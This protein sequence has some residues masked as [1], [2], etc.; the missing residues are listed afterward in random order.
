MADEILGTTTAG[1]A[2]TGG[3]EGGAAPAA[4]TAPS[5]APSPAPSGSSLGGETSPQAAGAQ[6]GQAQ[7]YLGVRDALA[8]YGVDLRTQFNDDHAALQHLALAYRQASQGNELAQYG[9]QYLQ[10]AGDFQAYLAQRQQQAVQQKQG[11]QEWFKA[12]EYDQRWQHQI[13]RD[14]ATGEMRPAPGAPPDV[15]QKY[16]AW[17]NHQQDFQTR[18]ARDP[19][20]TLKPGLEQLVQET[21]QRLIEQQLGG[22]QERT[23]AQGF[24]Q[25]HSG[26]LH[27]RDQQGNVVLDPRTGRP[28]LSDLGQ[29]FAGYVHE[30][31]QFG[32]RDVASQQKYAMGLVQRDYLAAQ[33]GGAQAQAQ[34]QANPAQLAADA[35]QATRDAFLANA[36]AH[37]PNVSG[38]VSPTAPNG[39]QP[40]QNT[41]LSLK[42]RL[43]Q[44]FTENG[45]QLSTPVMG[46]R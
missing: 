15:V 16:V 10:H 40:S 13:T 22:Y 24:V 27:A 1:G 28:A 20:G 9:R 33:A 23:Q 2:S 6:T 14:P 3:T 34:P 5:P 12:P 25:Q 4:S 42:D 18:M 32:L 21:A 44:R 41:A 17:A 37:R 43:A 26:W 36:A 38:S 7:D 11:Q 35:N 31:E 8:A 39:Q 46:G 45:Y 19:I 29:R 30:A